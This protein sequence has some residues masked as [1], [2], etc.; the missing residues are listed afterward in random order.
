[1]LTGKVD[2]ERDFDGFKIMN[3]SGIEVVCNCGKKIYFGEEVEVIGL[4]E[5]YEWKKQVRVLE[6]STLG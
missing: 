5:E 4:V 2:S 6:I 1:M 3:V